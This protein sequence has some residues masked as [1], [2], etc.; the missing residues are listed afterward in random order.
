MFDGL[1]PKFVTCWRAALAVASMVRDVVKTFM[2]M[3]DSQNRI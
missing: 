3:V 1:V 2:L